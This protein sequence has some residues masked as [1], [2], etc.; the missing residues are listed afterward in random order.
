[1]ADEKKAISNHN[2]IM[3]NRSNITI[4]GVLD[5]ISFD[6][7]TIIS[8]TDIGVLIIRGSNLHVSKMNL[9]TGDMEIDGEI[10]SL[11]YEEESGHGKGKGKSIFGNIFK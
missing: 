5:V 11:T 10:I 4:T 3:E 8:D 6:E 2:V 7:E 9:D 1:M